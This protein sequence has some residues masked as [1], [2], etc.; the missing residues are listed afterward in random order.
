M[1]KI[2]DK[3]SLVITTG[4]LAESARSEEYNR[5]RSFFDNLATKLK[6]DRNSFIFVPGNHDVDWIACKRVELDQEEQ[7]FSEE[8]FVSRMNQT[9]F[10]NFEIFSKDFYGIS[11]EEKGHP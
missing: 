5:T 9:K 8:E 7:R 6:I 10:K 3:I 11:L 4:D 2:D 1:R